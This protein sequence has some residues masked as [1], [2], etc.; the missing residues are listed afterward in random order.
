VNKRYRKIACWLRDVERALAHPAQNM[1]EAKLPEL[2]WSFGLVREQ[3][4]HQPDRTRELFRLLNVVRNA[5]GAGR[6]IFE[7]RV[8]EGLVL[9][10]AD[11]C[12]MI[13]DES[14][15][16]KPLAT[17]AETILPD[18][19][20][21]FVALQG[22][23]LFALDCFR[24]SRPRD[25][26]SGERR[27][28]AFELIAEVSAVIEPPAEF[29][30]Y[31]RKALSRVRDPEVIG[32]ILFCEMYYARCGGVPDEMAPLLLGAIEKTK[33]RRTV[34]GVLSVFVESGDMHEFEALDRM[35]D[36][37]ERNGC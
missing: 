33:S 32:A 36:W 13:Y 1:D 17:K 12:S 18:R 26:F 5:S 9:S 30:D 15:S 7:R 4:V 2:G 11:V 10:A 28:Q 24:F 20:D 3:L 19:R 31:L 29:F 35:D 37:R 21:G 16:P 22:L 34:S 27:R 8:L 23:C 6:M 14:L 25:S